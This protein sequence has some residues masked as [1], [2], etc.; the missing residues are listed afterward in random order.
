M[1]EI[2]SA[3]QDRAGGDGWRAAART[4]PE[5]RPV[6]APVVLAGLG[7]AL[8][9]VALVAGRA[10]SEVLLDAGAVLL[11]VGGV[12][13]LLDAGLARWHGSGPVEAQRPRSPRR[14]RPAT[15]GSASWGSARSSTR[16]TCSGACAPARSCGGWTP[17]R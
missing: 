3:T 13:L 4:V 6:T 11:T 5:R 8:V 15:T 17:S 12:G 9:V 1:L 7:A 2:R 16:S 14:R 10:W